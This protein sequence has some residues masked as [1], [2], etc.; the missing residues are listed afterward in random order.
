MNYACA[1]MISSQSSKDDPLSQVLV[2][3]GASSA[4]LNRLEARGDW[5]LS[6]PEKQRLKLVA[7]IRGECWICLPRRAPKRVVE[8]DVL[9]IG[10][11]PYVVA[12]DPQRAPVDGVSRYAGQQSL[13]LGDGDDT[14]LLGAGILF[15]GENSGFLIDALPRL[16]KIQSASPS[17]G[18]V[19]T[20]LDL[21]D[22]E[23]GRHRTGSARVA[24][25]L[26]EVL[27]VEAIRAY[28]HA[29]TQA[30]ISWIGALGDRHIGAALALMHGDVAHAW[31]VAELA[32]RVGLSRSAFSSRFSQKVGQAPLHYLTQWRMLL[33]HRLLA[34]TGLDIAHVA[35]RVGYQSPSA[36]G[37][38]FKR[39]FGA[40]PKRLVRPSET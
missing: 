4:G 1:A 13:R 36:F 38:A 25:C 18:A 16:M 3:L 27:V 26:S 33:A 14:V 23:M 7:L 31:T 8:G 29:H 28:M 6:F 35:E 30:H 21:L 2:A 20:T 12:S 22:A 17:A 37:H 40:A 11:T 24:S 5:A 10:N 34:E 32:S 15:S 39:M 19:R 9:L